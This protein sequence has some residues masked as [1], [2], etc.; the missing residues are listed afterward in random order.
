VEVLRGVLDPRQ[1]SRVEAFFDLLPEVPMD[2]EL[3]Q[4]AADLAW[5]L[6]RE[7][8]V[9]PVTDLII[10]VS[11][12]DSGAAVITRN[13]HFWEVPGLECRERV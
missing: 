10:A 11:A 7:G 13:K 2:R 6:D 4:K 1:R 9:L 8:R 5:K 3:W 12:L